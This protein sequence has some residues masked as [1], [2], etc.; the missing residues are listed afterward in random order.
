M[1]LLSITKKNCKQKIYS[2]YDIYLKYVESSQVRF[3]QLHEG[4]SS[5][6]D[7]QSL[8]PSH[9]QDI[10]IHLPVWQLIKQNILLAK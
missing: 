7:E 1:F 3:D 2:T 4:G 8:S 5:S 6:F 9:F 10:G